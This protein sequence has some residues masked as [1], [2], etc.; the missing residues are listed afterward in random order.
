M[1]KGHTDRQ[2][3]R[4]SVMAWPHRRAAMQSHDEIS[5]TAAGESTKGLGGEGVIL[6]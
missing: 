5:A 4:R 6:E 2:N 1:R 3:K